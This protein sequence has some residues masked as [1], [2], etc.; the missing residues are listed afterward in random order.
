MNRELY[1]ALIGAVTIASASLPPHFLI[2]AVAILS[3]LMSREL[4]ST[5]GEDEVSPL[6][7][8]SPAF[9]WVSPV[10]GM[11]YASFVSLLFGT[12]KWEL[13][14]F[15]KTFFLMIYVGFFPSYLVLVRE[16][17]FLP[18]LTLILT[19]WTHDISAY[20]LG[21]KF[22]KK[23]LF[24]KLS[25]KKTI[26][27]YV[28]GFTAGAVV[29]LILSGQELLKGTLMAVIV[30]TAGAL[31]DYFKSFIK[32]QKGIKDFSSA[33][34]EHGGFVDRFDALIFSAPVYYWL[35]YGL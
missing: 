15:V 12:K 19:I 6:G 13:D 23:V 26:E 2:I 27:G 18:L 21:K 3:Y 24:E 4:A 20:Y 11:L 30:L 7:F 29:F 17:G 22:G 28:A 35:L 1:G 34:G 14:S 32:R 33:L 9:F 16:E 25:P 5:L 10:A 31:G 8:L